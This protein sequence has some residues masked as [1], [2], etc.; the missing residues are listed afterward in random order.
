MAATVGNA[1]QRHLV[2]ACSSAGEW[3]VDHRGLSSSTSMFLGEPQIGRVKKIK[4]SNLLWEVF[5]CL[6]VKKIKQ[7]KC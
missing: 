5:G 4:V 3:K 2:P 6:H 1:I 7:R